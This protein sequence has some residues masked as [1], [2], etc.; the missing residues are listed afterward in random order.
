MIPRNI[1]TRTSVS[2]LEKQ[3][4][5]YRL[6]REENV[7]DAENPTKL[8]N[9]LP[10]EVLSCNFHVLS[11]AA[12]NTACAWFAPDG[13]P[14]PIARSTIQLFPQSQAVEASELREVSE[15][16]GNCEKLRL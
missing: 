7:F 12:P 3:L 9:A 16:L 5:I 6:L 2:G 10:P 15:P 4:Q 1:P 13:S 8:I 14:N 11:G